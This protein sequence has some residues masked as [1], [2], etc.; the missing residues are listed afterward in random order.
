MAK[1]EVDLTGLEKVIKKWF[2][3]N[4]VLDPGYEVKGLTIAVGPQSVP[5]IT[6]T[7]VDGRAF[8]PSAK[9]KQG[10]NSKSSHSPERRIGLR[11]LRKIGLSVSIVNA[12]GKAGINTVAAIRN[13]Q[14]DEVTLIKGISKARAQKIKEALASIDV[15]VDWNL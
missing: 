8:L 5:V 1:K 12:L 13:M 7:R 3:E 15:K 6:I 11:R 9:G 10:L 4:Q 2:D 14:L